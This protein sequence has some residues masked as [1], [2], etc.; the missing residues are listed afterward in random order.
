MQNICLLYSGRRG[1]D[2]LTTRISVLR[3]PEVSRKLKETQMMIDEILGTNVKVDLY[4]FVQ[5]TEEEFSSQSS[6]KSLVA[7]AVQAGLFDRF[8]KYRS[9]PQFLVGP[10]NGNS[11]MK[12]CAGLQSFRDFVETSDYC[13]ENTLMARYTQQGTKLAGVKLEDYGA[14]MW[15]P[16]GFYQNLEM[17]KKEASKIVEELSLNNLLAQCVHLGPSFE[18]HA[19]EFNDVGLNHLASM[20]SIEMDPILNSFWKT[21]I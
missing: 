3:I 10:I 9:R 19:Q 11:A 18:F 13:K 1:L 7:A 17:D 8:V 15:N 16:E 4:S 6:L 5:S 12:V 20:S 2:D 14:M 21:A